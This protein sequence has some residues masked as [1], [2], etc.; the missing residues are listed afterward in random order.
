MTRCRKP[1]FCER[2]EIDFGVYD[3]KSERVLPRTGKEEN[4]CFYI[5]ENFY[6]VYWEKSRKDSLVNGVGEIEA[7]LKFFKN[8]KPKTI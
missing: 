2:C 4:I 6:C 1:D 8:K 5:H 3:L 7:K